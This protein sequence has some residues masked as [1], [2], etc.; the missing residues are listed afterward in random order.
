MLGVLENEVVC[1]IKQVEDKEAPQAGLE[2]A[3]PRGIALARAVASSVTVIKHHLTDGTRE[4]E[5]TM[6]CGPR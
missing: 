6:P 5:E 3:A 4:G 2:V 1:S